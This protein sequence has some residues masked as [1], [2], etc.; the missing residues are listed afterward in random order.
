MRQDEQTKQH[1]L[2]LPLSTT[3]GVDIS[4]TQLS[5]IVRHLCSTHSPFPFPSRSRSRSPLSPQPCSVLLPPLFLLSTTTL[6]C[7]CALSCDY[8][9]I[10]PFRRAAWMG[11]AIRICGHE[12]NHLKCRL[13]YIRKVTVVPDKSPMVSTATQGTTINSQ[14]HRAQPSTARKGSEVEQQ[15]P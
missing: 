11:G 12:S 4:G 9:T 6:L 10:H 5:L 15:S 7:S 1:L 3:S 8:R 2:V 13:A 14:P